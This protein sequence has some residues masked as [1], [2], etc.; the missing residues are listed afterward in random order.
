MAKGRVEYNG[1]TVVA[2]VERDS[3]TGVPKSHVEQ[4]SDGNKWHCVDGKDPVLLRDEADY[5]AVVADK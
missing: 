5:A 2:V 4:D 3:A 1:G